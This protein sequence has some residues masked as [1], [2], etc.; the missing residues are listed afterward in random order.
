MMTML[1]AGD[2]MMRL[3]SSVRVM[4]VG[5]IVV[6]GL[7]HTFTALA[8]FRAALLTLPVDVKQASSAIRFYLLFIKLGAIFPPSLP[9]IHS[10]KITTPNPHQTRT[11]S[12]RTSLRCQICCMKLP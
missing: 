4:I 6:E 2:A 7:K 11:C 10:Q 12:C 1:A 3:K 9:F 5:F 8:F